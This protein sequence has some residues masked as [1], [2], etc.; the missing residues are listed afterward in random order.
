MKMPT[1]VGIFILIS[2]EIFML[3]WVEHEKSFI[4]SGPDLCSPVIHSII[5]NDS[6]N[7]QCALIRLQGCAGWPG[8]LL[9]A[10]APS[11]IF[12]LGDPFYSGLMLL[13][14]LFQSYLNNVWMRQGTQWSLLECC[15]TE[16]SHC[17]NMIQYSTQSHYTDSGAGADQFWFSTFSLLNT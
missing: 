12:A 4:T 2:R 7:R 14:T 10:Y 13:S 1:V 16:I 8:L 17:S 9:S 6:V 15:L 3:S 5:S 11:H